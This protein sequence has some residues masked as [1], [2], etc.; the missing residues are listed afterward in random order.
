MAYK[1]IMTVVTDIEQDADALKAAIKITRA[2]SGH[3][4]VLCLGLDRTQ[5]GFY[6]SGA[7]ALIIQENLSHAQDNAQELQ[8]QVEAMLAKEDILWTCQSATAQM[9]ALNSLI[10]HHAR[11]ADLVV[12]AKPYGEGRLR[13]NEA[14]VEAALFD[15]HVPVMIIP[16]GSDFPDQIDTTI[17]AWN[18]SPEALRA[19]RSA[20]P[21]LIGSQSVDIT[22]INPPSHSPERSD[23]GGALSQMLVRHGVKANVSVLAKT[24]TR[25]SEVLCRHC[26]DKEADLLVMGA[27]GHSRFREAILGGATRNMLES[28]NV[29]VL[30]AH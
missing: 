9:A 25:V 5:P 4:D 28:S 14:I 2:Q 13:E 6:Y 20:M 3:L 22:L 23:P 7:S 29:P 12:S 26:T 15:G 19:I 16:D 1:S 17:I 11:L 30:L 24:L 21:F 27:Y 18:E 8:R 10:A